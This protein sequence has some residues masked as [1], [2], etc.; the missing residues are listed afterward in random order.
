MGIN[1]D[2]KQQRTGENSWWSNIGADKSYQNDGNW[3]RVLPPLKLSLMQRML[4]A[5]EK[6][7]YRES[8][9]YINQDLRNRFKI[10]PIRGI[11]GLKTPQ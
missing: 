1:F 2:R 9:I 10:L 7:N 4:D 6:N 5:F 8:G 3:L 11:K